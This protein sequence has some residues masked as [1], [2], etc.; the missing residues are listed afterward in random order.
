MGR[1][2]LFNFEV[3]NRKYNQNSLERSKE[4]SILNIFQMYSGF[5][6]RH[7]EEIS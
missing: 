7:E 5:S 4:R 6:S 2:K 1:T 3:K